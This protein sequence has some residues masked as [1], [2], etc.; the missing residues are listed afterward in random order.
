[1]KVKKVSIKSVSEDPANA[2]SHSAVNIEAIENSLKEF[3]QVEPLVVH[4]STHH[5]IGGNA[6]LS[7]MKKMGWKQID[8]VEIDLPPDKTKALGIA[9][10]RTG[11]LATWNKDVLKKTLDDL[12]VNKFD[13]SKLGWKD[14]D[15]E[16]LVRK[17][18]K[19]S[20]TA[21]E[22]TEEKSCPECGRAYE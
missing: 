7:I 4:K 3:G 9:L 5:V 2:R 10:N 12:K 15:L 21:E 8:I 19:V 16:G 18:K 17:K 20:F 11:E 14:S 6:R 22:K 13:I 1:M